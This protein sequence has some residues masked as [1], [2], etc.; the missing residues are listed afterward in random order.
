MRIYIPALVTDLRRFVDEGTVVV[1]GGTAFALTPALREHYISGDD[2]ELE[3]IAFRQ[4]ARSSLR[5]LSGAAGDTLPAGVASR[6][7]VVVSADVDDDAVTCRPDL[8]TAVVRLA[9]DTIAA[10]CVAAVHVDL[11]MA[12][13]V[14][15]AAVA[16]SAAADMGDED[17]ELVVGDAEDIE[18]AWYAPEEVP[19]LLDLS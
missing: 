7:R 12:G 5:L 4:A 16:A 17:A 3:D 13:D 18:L 8:D 2:E 1:R 19:F 10:R 6:K 9:E 15:A 14:V 11:D